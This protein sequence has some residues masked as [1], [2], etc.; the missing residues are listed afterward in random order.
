MQHGFTLEDITFT[1]ENNVL[2]VAEIGTSHSGSIKKAKEL[3]CAAVDSGATA[4][5]T[6]IVFADEILHPKTG[7]VD[8]P[9]GKIPL[10]DYFKTL[11][12]PDSFF[13]ELAEYCTKK[14][15]L[16]SASP[17]GIRS[18]KLLK[19]LQ[20]AFVKIAS[21]ELNHFPL[22]EEVAKSK[23][24]LIL[25]GGVSML[26]DIDVALNVL[27]EYYG[28]DFRQ[29]VAFLHC[30]TSYPAPE[31]DYNV[32]VLKSLSSIFALPVG[33]SDHSLDEILVPALSVANGGCIIEKHLCLSKSDG[34]LDDPVALTPKQFTKMVKM[35][36]RLKGKTRNDI[37]NMLENKGY[38]KTLLSKIE[39]TGIKKLA[40]SEK[41]NYRK[42]N[43]SLHYTSDLPCGHIIKKNDIAILRT[44]KILSVGESPEHENLFFGA[45]LQHNVTAGEGAK[46][47]D[48]I[49]RGTSDDR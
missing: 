30:V 12:Q 48:I 49:Q 39:G 29:K 25:S 2:I 33:I 13:F 34:G 17:F 21:P 16:F 35:I 7:N 5:K 23:P 41:E 6:Q 1:A 26:K 28:F 37:I 14:G 24:S 10:Y 31:H 19:Q 44:E 42:T 27:E 47:N 18:A 15:V 22:L 20:P 40:E 11:E 32:S 4:V 45:V 3:V 8:L 46:F 38:S 9:T 43:R 36:K